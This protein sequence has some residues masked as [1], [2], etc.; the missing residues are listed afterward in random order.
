M[1]I[2]LIIF[3]QVKCE[4]GCACKIKYRYE[5]HFQNLYDWCLFFSTKSVKTKMQKQYTNDNDVNYS[6][7][8]QRGPD[9]CYI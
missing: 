9:L 7:L 5:T 2:S 1:K 4:G 3:I 8:I 6:L